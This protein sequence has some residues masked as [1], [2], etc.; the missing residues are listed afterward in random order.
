[1]QSP[2][3]ILVFSMTTARARHKTTPRRGNGSKRLSLRAIRGGTWLGFVYVK[4][5]GVPQDYVKAR[6]WFERAPPAATPLRCFD[7]GVLYENGYGVPQD[8][9]KAR[10]WYE[11][12]FAGGDAVGRRN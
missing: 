11:K 1:M 3:A 2:C 5:W 4:G 12:A 7:L 8:Y 9:A 6:E 10:Q